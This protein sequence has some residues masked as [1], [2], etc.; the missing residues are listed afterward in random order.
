MSSHTDTPRILC[1]DFNTPQEERT[2][3]ETITF[4]D[5]PRWREAE[6][7]VLRGLSGFDLS[8]VYRKLHGYRRQDFSW[9]WQDR[10]KG[11][12]IGRRFDHIFASERLNATSCEYLHDLRG[13]KY[14]DHSAIEAIFEQVG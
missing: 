5:V 10:S 3:G 1:G 9:C 14:S 2:N 12:A 7:N 8:D 4:G 11:V 6:W 13:S